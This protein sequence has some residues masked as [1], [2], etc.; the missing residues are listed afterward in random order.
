MADR[1][2]YN[3]RIQNAPIRRRLDRR[4]VSWVMLSACIGAVVAAFFVYSARC[5]FEAVALGYETQQRRTEIDQRQ[6]ERRRLELERTRALSPEELESRARRI[7]LT[8]PNL[9]PAE[10]VAAVTRLHQP[11]R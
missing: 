9:V 3:K 5:H 2:Y 10:G 8:E 1:Y 11:G 4:F 6:E 7:G